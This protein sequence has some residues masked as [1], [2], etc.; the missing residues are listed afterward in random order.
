VQTLMPVVANQVGVHGHVAAHLRGRHAVDAQTQ[1]PIET[2]FFFKDK[3]QSLYELGL[4][5]HR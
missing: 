3:P 5:N 1:H 4:I 2:D